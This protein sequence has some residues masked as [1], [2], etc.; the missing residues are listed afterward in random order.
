VRV[1]SHFGW[2]NSGQL[3]QPRFYWVSVCPNSE[4]RHL[5]HVGQTRGAALVPRVP[6]CR[7][8]TWDTSE[9]RI[10]SGVPTVPT[11]T[12]AGNR[13]VGEFLPHWANRFLANGMAVTI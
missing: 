11:K 2:D 9:P 12:Q 4:E 1:Y 8:R 7:K 13:S 10:Y 5:G 3:G 6:T